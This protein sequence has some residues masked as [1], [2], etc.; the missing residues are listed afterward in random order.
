MILRFRPSAF[1]AATLF[2]TI[3]AS[4]QTPLFRHFTEETHGAPAYVYDMAQGPDGRL[5]ISGGSFVL[6]FDGHRFDT[7][8]DG[9]KAG[10]AITTLFCNANGTLLLALRQGGVIAVKNGSRP[11]KGLRSNVRVTSVASSD[12]Q[13]AYL[14]TDRHG[15]WK[16]DT[17]NEATQVIE[18]S[19]QVNVIAFDAQHRLLIGTPEHLYLADLSRPG[20][21]RTLLDAHVIDVIEDDRRLYVLTEEGLSVFSRSQGAAQLLFSPEN[22]RAFRIQNGRALCSDEDGRLWI[23]TSGQGCVRVMLHSNKDAPTQIASFNSNEGLSANAET[24]FRDRENNLWF[25]TFGDGLFELPSTQA[26]LFTSEHGLCDADVRTIAVGDTAV[27]LGGP[28]GITMF[29]RA[30]ARSVFCDTT[31]RNISAL[32]KSHNGLLWVGTEDNG[33]FTYDPALKRWLHVSKLYASTHVTINDISSA[34]QRVVVGSNSG[35]FVFSDDRSAPEWLRTNE[36][37]LHNS[38]NH[39]FLDA[40]KRL[41][42]SS[43][44][45]PP[46]FIE[47]GRAVP[48]RN[49]PGLQSFR[50]NAVCQSADGAV[51]VA[52]EGDGVFR[53]QDEVMEKFGAGEG[54]L[55]DYCTGI[56]AAENN[57][58][59]THRTGVSIKKAEQ[60]FFRSLPKS[61]GFPA[62]INR[63]A[64]E[65]DTR[66]NVWVGTPTGLVKLK[67][68][69]TVPSMLPVNITSVVINGEIFSPDREIVKAYGRY[70]VRI[71]F[72]TVTLSHPEGTTYR[73]RLLDADTSWR[74][75]PDR[76]VEFAQL[77]EGEYRFEVVAESSGGYIHPADS[78][79]FVIREPAW[80]RWWFYLILLLAVVMVTYTIVTYRTRTYRRR[81]L[82]LELKVKQK[83][84]LLE[85][86]KDAVMAMK[87]AL[88][89]KNKDITDSISYAKKIQDSILPPEEMLQRLFQDNHF[90]LFRPKDIVSGDIYWAG[91]LQPS[92][93]TRRPLALGAVIDCTGHGVPG[94]FL[95]IMANDFLK[96]SL[97][98]PGVESPAD[99]LNFLNEKVASHLNQTSGSQMPDGMDLSL[100]GI[101]YVGKTLIYSGAN[102]PLYIFRKTGE[103]IDQI[104]LTPSKQPI[105]LITDDTQKFTNREFKL[106]SGDMIYLFSDGFADQFGG[107][108]NKKLTYKR[109]REYLAEAFPLPPAAQ[110]VLLASKFDAWKDIENQTDDVCVMGIRIP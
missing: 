79:T 95:S 37:L 57:V 56:A 99:I 5:Y 35:L 25:G 18:L 73:Y 80:R 69:K 43:H 60:S 29:H 77:S 87:Q 16:T 55:S 47:H 63:N 104:I 24:I 58:W 3:T 12:S 1:F 2:V 8:Y 106:Q 109:F 84:L 32:L 103:T 45:A 49:I 19:E 23:A 96:Q 108:H 36:G 94:A 107:V 97:A 88:E 13:V 70:T 30:K 6:S 98:E 110:K 4:A 10:Q 92:S 17:G 54:L 38:V 105:G 91:L 100:T 39:V 64:V 44:G 83:T 50:I 75:T 14:G 52:T 51:W 7:I 65:T 27:W 42:I 31:V 28:R 85:R 82:L 48:L 62:K 71:D 9:G 81:Q 46:Y 22:T 53:L 15:I 40:A 34:G 26:E 61:P 102:N 33:L 74:S 66:G 59:V 20:K 67:V 11:L 93:P 76:H 86:E 68:A 41:W 101:D 21:L 78:V 90:V 89:E 72:L